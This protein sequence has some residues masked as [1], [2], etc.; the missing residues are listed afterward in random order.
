MKK[1]FFLFLIVGFLVAC[2]STTNCPPQ[3]SVWLSPDGFVKCPK[4][5]FDDENHEKTWWTEKELEKMYD[6]YLKSIEQES[7]MDWQR[8]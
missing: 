4:G 8:L 3:D 7:S 2:V 5:F 6:D 1:L